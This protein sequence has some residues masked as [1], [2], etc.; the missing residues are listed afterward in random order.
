MIGWYPEGR[1]ALLRGEI[2]ASSEPLRL[3]LVSSAYEFDDAHESLADIPS[4]AIVA[5]SPVLA[6]V[7]ITANVLS[8]DSVSIQS[9]SGDPV[10]GWVLFVDRS[11]D[12]AS[13]LL[14]FNDGFLPIQVAADADT[15]STA[16]LFEAFPTNAGTGAELALV[17]GTGP[18]T[19][20]L[21]EDVT[22]GMREVPVEVLG[23]PVE[24]GALYRYQAGVGFPFT[25]TG[26]PVAIL[27]DS[28]GIAAL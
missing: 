18:A 13:K 16:V 28:A 22:A 17:S 4:G 25:P 2:D 5:T 27:F 1:G 9:V 6:N 14:V 19:I 26:G 7:D 15:S 3:A 21:D 23:E 11:D 20:T 12:E 24:A 10:A 8:S